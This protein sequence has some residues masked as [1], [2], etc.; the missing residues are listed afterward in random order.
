M[1]PTPRLFSPAESPSD[2][3]PA[4]PT[5]VYP[6]ALDVI[7]EAI[8]RYPACRTQFGLFS[9]LH[10]SIRFLLPSARMGVLLRQPDACFDLLYCFPVTAREAMRVFSDQLIDSGRFAQAL[11]QGGCHA[12]DHAYLL[13]RIATPRRISGMAV[14]VD[15]VIPNC[16]HQTVGALIDL[17]AVS[18]DHRQGMTFLPTA[19][20]VQTNAVDSGI[21][22]D[23]AIPADQLTGLAQRAHFIR[24]LQRVV[25]ERSSCTAIGV[26]LLDID[27][28]HHVNRE[29]GSETG[30]HIL[31]DVALR[32]ENALQ[33]RFLYE[34]LGITE[35]DLCFARTGADE[36]GLA[37]SCI[38]Y[39]E[40]L[41]EIAADL[42]SH[43]SEGFSQEGENLHLSFSIGAAFASHDDKRA[44]A[45]ELLS[46]SDTALKRAKAA[47]RNQSLVFDAGWDAA[48]SPRLRI[49]SLL[50][51][52]L[53]KDRFTLNF[54]PLFRLADQRLIGAE[55]LLRLPMEDGT[56]LP[57]SNFIPIAESSG[58]IVD[59][60]EWVLRRTCRQMRAWDAQGFP[61]L[62]LSINV[63][64]IELSRGDL[65]QR[66]S[67]II[68]QEHI[69]AERLHIEITETAIARDEDQALANLRS[70]RSAGF[71]IWIDDFGIGYS[72]LKSIK[73]FPISGLK[74]DRE[75]VKDL[76]HDP[77]T[78]VIASTIL[79]M[80]Q[81]LNHPVIAEGIE[82][83]EQVQ[84]LQQHG[85]TSGQ[86]YHLGY[87]VGP[88]VF[89]ASY[90]QG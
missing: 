53:R 64:A 22:D 35:R 10:Q 50:Q 62:P 89:Q 4:T 26:I 83:E 74:L 54:Q 88:E 67:R 28:F 33:S 85:C 37:L 12:A 71:E 81:R 58:Q 24:F 3:S 38:R 70:L 84:F 44:S 27:R 31:R 18:L 69:T 23:I 63:S 1:E 11:Q 39:P 48:G 15:R 56:H 7:R 68:Q 52:A 66:L 30:D 60:S 25:L 5:N 41:A 49:E 6:L 2:S 59:I 47:G 13:Q 73:N 16:L 90:F 21:I 40:R 42:H 86:G 55:V 65:T 8:L 34:T 82:N 14:L 19:R 80:A 77:M 29:F 46:R 32:L 9:A 51:E 57:P 43:L 17:A 87:P 36:F 75:F 61:S 79:T 72:S 78:E 45:K 20:S 76:A